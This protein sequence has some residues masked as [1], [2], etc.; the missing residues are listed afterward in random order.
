MHQVRKSEE[1]GHASTCYKIFSILSAAQRQL[2][3]NQLR[4]ALRIEPGDTVWDP[5]R[6]PDNMRDVLKKYGSLIVTDAEEL[7]VYFT[8]HSIE[9]Y[10]TSPSVVLEPQQYHLHPFNAGIGLGEIFSTY[11]NLERRLI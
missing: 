4:E 9:D 3:L 10:I 7:M 11:L 8:H 2:S 6:L 5:L 1:T